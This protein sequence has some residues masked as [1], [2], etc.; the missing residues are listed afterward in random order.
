VRK[1]D[2]EWKKIYFEPGECS[3]KEYAIE[4]AKN[5]ISWFSSEKY[6]K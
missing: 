1:F 5:N 6:L 2:D 4:M 3:L